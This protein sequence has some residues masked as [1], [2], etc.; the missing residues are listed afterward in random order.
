MLGVEG[1]S[2][3]PDYIIMGYI[4][5][6]YVDIGIMEQKMVTTIMGYNYP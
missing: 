2:A 6:L 5:G 3:E 1:F 4:L